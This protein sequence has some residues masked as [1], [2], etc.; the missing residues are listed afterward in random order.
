MMKIMVRI[1]GVT[2]LEYEEMNQGYNM[3]GKHDYQSQEGEG[4][5]DDYDS[6]GEEEEEDREIQQDQRDQE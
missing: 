6:E 1:R 4:S 5:Q 2:C 3:Q